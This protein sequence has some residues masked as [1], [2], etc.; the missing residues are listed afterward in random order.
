MGDEL[1]FPKSTWYCFR[2]NAGDCVRLEAQVPQKADLAQM[3]MLGG[4]RDA[5]VLLGF[6]P[7]EGDKE[8]AK[9]LM[10]ARCALRAAQLLLAAWS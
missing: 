2:R 10:R 7:G 1:D 9:K 5:S 3:R 6:M 8:Q 4:S